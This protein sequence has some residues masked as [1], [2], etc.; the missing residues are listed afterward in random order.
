MVPSLLRIIIDKQGRV[1]YIHVISAF[2]EQSAALTE[3]LL[4]W[5]FKPYLKN[6]RS[7]EIETDHV[8]PRSATAGS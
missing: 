8:R 7:V 5:R 3:A 4:Q 2:A 6:G 1:K